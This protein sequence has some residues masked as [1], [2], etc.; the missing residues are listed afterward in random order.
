MQLTTERILLQ[1]RV[2]RE[3]LEFLPKQLVQVE[4]RSRNFAKQL[5]QLESQFGILA[6]QLSTWS[7]RAVACMDELSSWW[8]ITL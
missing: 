2:I 4:F 8:T 6:D 3:D 5:T 1:V 7:R